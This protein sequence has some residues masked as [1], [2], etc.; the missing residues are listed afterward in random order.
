DEKR[1]KD[2]SQWCM[3][4]RLQPHWLERRSVLKTRPMLVESGFDFI[5]NVFRFLLPPVDDEPA[6]AFGKPCP[7]KEN[8]DTEDGTDE[9]CEPPADVRIEAGGIQKSDRRSSSQRATDPERAV[10]GKVGPSAIARRDHFLNRRIDR[11]V[12]AAYSS[13]SQHSK[14]TK[15]FQIP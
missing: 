11:T 6:W 3:R 5:H 7:E 13:A 10:D 1:M 14:Q 8:D 2:F 4:P 15:A 12:F 9:K